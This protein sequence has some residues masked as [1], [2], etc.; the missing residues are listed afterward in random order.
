MKLE[1]TWL[2]IG[3]REVIFDRIS[4]D[5]LDAAVALDTLFQK[6]AAILE[7]HPRAG[8]LGRVRGTR[9]LIAHRHYVLVYDVLPDSVRILR[10]RHTSQKWPP[11]E[12]TPTPKRSR[13]GKQPRKK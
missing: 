7:S 10:V 6:K 2:A 11:M 4:A 13:G 1:W 12:W 5:N 3:D 9:E 8:R